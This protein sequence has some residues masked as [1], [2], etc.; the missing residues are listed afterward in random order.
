[1]HVLQVVGEVGLNGTFVA[2]HAG[3]AEHRL[4]KLDKLI[5]VRVHPLLNENFG[6]HS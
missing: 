6:I 4:E 5:A 3:N 1:M 2:G